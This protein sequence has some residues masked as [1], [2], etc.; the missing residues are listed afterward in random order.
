[1]SLDRSSRTIGWHRTAVP[2]EVMQE[3][4]KRSDL[5]GLLQIGTHISLILLTGALAWK[6][7][8]RIYLL[9]PVLFC[10]GTFYVFILN[11][12]VLWKSQYF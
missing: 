3:L 5:K 4:N 12:N 8:D 1:M 10:Y 6:V 7:Q 11:A 2:H 9:L